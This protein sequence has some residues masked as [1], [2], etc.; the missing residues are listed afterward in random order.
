MAKKKSYTHIII[1][2]KT[3]VNNNNKLILLDFHNTGL[4]NNGLLQLFNSFENITLKHIYL[5][6]NDISNVDYITEYI[7]N[8]YSQLETIY[9]SMNSLNKNEKSLNRLLSSMKNNKFIKR[10]CFS[11]CELNDFFMFDLIYIPNLCM[12]DFGMYKGT[13]DLGLKIN[14][15]T[16][17]SKDKI[18]RFINRHQKLQY[19]NFNYSYNNK[20]L[21]DINE[22]MSVILTTKKKTIH[23]NEYIQRELK[24]PQM[25]VNILQCI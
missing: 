1:S 18:I 7:I 3:D 12:I 13:Y 9:I 21:F 8:G 17:V 4:R 14:K 20:E 22:D 5:D 11:S 16:D 24:H 6:A 25:I 10:L 2:V 23:T 19:I 15:F